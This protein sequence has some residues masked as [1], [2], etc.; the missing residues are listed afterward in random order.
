MHSVRE[1]SVDLSSENNQTT[2]HVS[3]TMVTNASN[4][5]FELLVPWTVFYNAVR[6]QL[7]R[8]WSNTADFKIPRKT[9]RKFLGFL[10]GVNL[11]NCIICIIILTRV[12]SEVI[13]ETFELIWSTTAHKQV[14]RS[15]INNNGGVEA[16][17]RGSN[18]IGY[19]KSIPLHETTASYVRGRESERRGASASN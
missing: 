2:V 9:I 10:S 11:Y 3:R 16:S 4:G 12:K 18:I 6:S 13:G 8:A 19:D 5:D 1:A 15:G 17:A 7:V 14:V